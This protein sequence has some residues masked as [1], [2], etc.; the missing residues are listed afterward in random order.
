[1]NRDSPLA[2]EKL[3][4]Y[5]HALSVYSRLGEPIASLSPGPAALDHLDRALESILENIVTAN[6]QRSTDA[7]RHS[8][9]VACGSALECAACLDILGIRT[10][11]DTGQREGAKKDLQ[12]IVAMVVGLARTDNFRVRER[13]GPWKSRNHASQAQD[14]DHERLDVYQLSLE[15]VRWVDQLI[16]NHGLKPRYDTKLD[17]SS[18]SIVLN[19]AEGNGRFTSSDHRKFIDIAYQSTLKCLVAI[20]L[21]VAGR[22]PGRSRGCPRR[23]PQTR[24]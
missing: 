1:M 14:F 3:H 16:G 9:G 17:S 20:D 21:V 23:P 7:R 13:A 4:A 12:R 11:L 8:F 5:Q 22:S 6:S 10:K 24:T 18:T 2:H 19:I 15:L